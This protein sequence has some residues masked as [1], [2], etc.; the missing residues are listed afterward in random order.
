VTKRAW[1]E[2]LTAEAI[3][4]T[5]DVAPGPPEILFRSD[6]LEVRRIL[7]GDGRNQVVTFESYHDDIGFE[8]CG[9]GEKFFERVGLTGVH[10]LTAGNDWYQ[11]PE[12][13]AALACIR[14]AVAGAD[15]V[16]AYGSS[17]GGY[18]AVRFADAILATHVLSLSPQY[19]ID[20]AIVRADRR[21]WWDQKRI[22]FLSAHNG[23]VECAAD[24]IVAYD[25][26]LALDRLHAELIGRDVPARLLR[27]P[28]GGH[29]V[30]TTLN[31]LGL[32]QPM[33]LAFCDQSI[34]PAAVEED[35]ARLRDRSAVWLSEY[36]VR[37]F[38][39]NPHRAHELAARAIEIS[40]GSAAMQHQFGMRLHDLGRYEEAIAAHRS[41]VAIQR[42]P[43]FMLS[44]SRS[45]YFA[46]EY[47][48]A[49]MWVEEALELRSYDDFYYHSAARVRL[50][51]GDRVGAWRYARTA[52]RLAKRPRTFWDLI[53]YG[54]HA[55]FG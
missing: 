41:A 52:F 13:D 3:I 54:M 24:I 8:R 50:A 42:H 16:L 25:P 38:S 15:R 48:D 17:M 22:A 35:F 53:Y 2:K 27:L 37:A 21:W 49:L 33:A 20:P 14:D 26:T 4:G 5:E 6:H 40:P 29:P 23:T 1:H 9:F 12:M 11:Y 7:A 46:G 45:L 10:V 44:L 47:A 32:L 19:S 43:I 28:Y 30:T 51:N 18:A 31:E 39:G 55:V 36:A 34:D